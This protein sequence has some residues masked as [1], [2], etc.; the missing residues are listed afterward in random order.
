[1]ALLPIKIRQLT[2]PDAAR[3]RDIRLEAL[4]ACPEAY[5]STLEAE[6]EQPLSWFEERLRDSDVFG[7]F[8]EGELA[9][10]VGYFTQRGRKR[11]HKGMLWGMY[12]RPGARNAGLGAALVETVVKHARARVEL[13]QL[14]VVSENVE[15]RRLYTRHGFVEYGLEKDALKQDGRYYDEILMAI[16]L[17]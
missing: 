15:A 2:S 8:Q 17:T 14:T 4:R 1:M 9:G 3:Y 7:A 6:R 10:V 11:A 16:S 13:L 12:V 5:G